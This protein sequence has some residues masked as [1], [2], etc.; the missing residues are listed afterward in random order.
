[1][2]ESDH[3][4]ITT[5]KKFILTQPFFELTDLGKWSDELGTFYE[6]VNNSP[7]DRSFVVLMTLI[8]E[9]H[10]DSVYKCFFPGYKEILETIDFTLSLKIKIL[11]GLKLVPDSIFNL[12]DLVRAIR[13]EFAHN[14]EI[15]NIAQLKNYSRGKK[16]I[17]KL[18]SLCHQYQE[19]CIY[20]KNDKEN[21]REKFKDIANFVN[22]SLREY[23]S[24]IQL[25]RQEIDKDSFINKIIE[26][27]KFKIIPN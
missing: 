17:S 22:S 15:D 10:I 5:D 19:Y 12:A 7:D 9:F 16:L 21:L 23:E 27:H 13:N 4:W 3:P 24:S 8:V 6:R 26:E 25:L 18:D 1:M 20:S 14:V 2:K 11:K